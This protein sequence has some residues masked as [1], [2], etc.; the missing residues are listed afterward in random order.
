LDRTEVSLGEALAG[1]LRPG[2]A[3]SNTAAGHIEDLDMSLASL[4]EEA[5]PKE[6]GGPEVLVRSDSAGATHDF[7]ADCR[8]RHC[9]FSLGCAVV[10]EKARL[11]LSMVPEEAWYEAIE[12]DDEAREGAFV[13]EVTK[14]LDLSPWP[15]GSR[16][17]VGR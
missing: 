2:N 6:D 11:A 3:G 7:A 14:V 8:A 15:E 10:E 12:Q 1:L 13:A 5:G 17:I 4:P 16:V 9:G